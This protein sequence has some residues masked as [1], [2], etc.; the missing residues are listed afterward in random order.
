M[1]VAQI[2]NLGFLIEAPVTGVNTTGSEPA[3]LFGFNGRGDFTFQENS[4]PL[5]AQFGDGNG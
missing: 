3:A 1:T 2:G 4:L 5:T